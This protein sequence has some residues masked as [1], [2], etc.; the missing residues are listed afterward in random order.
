[1]N[2]DIQWAIDEPIRITQMS[3]T[4]YYVE[5]VNG[6]DSLTL[7]FTPD[8]HMY[9]NGQYRD[10]GDTFVQ[11]IGLVDEYHDSPDSAHGG[12]ITLTP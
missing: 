9:I 1:M 4:A 12:T 6:Q 3:D 8:A 10:L 11:F 5:R 2:E 7:T